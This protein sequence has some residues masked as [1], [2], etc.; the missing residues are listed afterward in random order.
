MAGSRTP[1]PSNRTYCP[2]RKA[3]KY[4]TRFTGFRTP[5][6]G[7]QEGKLWGIGPPREET[8]KWTC[9]FKPF[10]FFRAPG[11]EPRG[12]KKQGGGRFLSLLA[13]IQ[14][15]GMLSGAAATTSASPGT[16]R[17]RGRAAHAPGCSNP[18]GTSA[19]SARLTGAT[20]PPV[21]SRLAPAL[22]GGLVL[23]PLSPCL[24]KVC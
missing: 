20:R 18:G 19:D 9:G 1:S 14:F 13:V 7:S 12:D 15:S 21:N 24:L 10:A 16:W 23:P 6:F 5:K 8:A 17:T 3:G 4:L 22:P 2:P 11:K